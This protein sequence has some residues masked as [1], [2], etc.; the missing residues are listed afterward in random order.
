MSNNL[1]RISHFQDSSNIGHQYLEMQ[2]QAVGIQDGMCKEVGNIE[3]AVT[4]KL[5]PF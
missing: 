2:Y 1:Q 5:I 3:Y 4:L